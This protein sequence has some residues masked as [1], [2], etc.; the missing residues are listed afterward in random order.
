MLWYLEEFVS[1]SKMPGW[2]G[3]DGMGREG[4]S[5]DG[6][7]VGA[8]YAMWKSWKINSVFYQQITRRNREIK[9]G[10]RNQT[11]FSTIWRQRAQ[12]WHS[13]LLRHDKHHATKLMKWHDA[14]WLQAQRYKHL[15]QFSI[16]QRCWTVHAGR[17]D[18]R[19]SAGNVHM[20]W[21]QGLACL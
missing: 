17:T 7:G 8:R 21:E 4:M 20:R 9:N 15:P 3:W 5:W 11:K 18:T 13:H 12:A 14:A 1:I 10:L 16:K 19:I 6:S 2:V